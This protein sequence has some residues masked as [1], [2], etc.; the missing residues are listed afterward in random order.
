MSDLASIPSLGSVSLDESDARVLADLVNQWSA[1]RSRNLLRSVYFD[2]KNALRDLGISIPPQLKTMEAVLGWPAKSVT[3]LSARCN[4]D[5]FVIPGGDQDPFDLG[6][7]LVDNNM[8]VE[9][10]QA[11]SSSLI[12]AV[13]FLT[14]T[15]GD[16][17]SGEPEVLLLARSAKDATGIW[18]RRT[19]SL[20]AGL[21]VM[22]TDPSTGMPTQ[23][24]MYQR[25]KVSTF[26]R[27]EGGK[28]IVDVRPNRLGRVWMEPLVFR[29]ELDRPFG[30]SRISRAVMS[31]TDS[32]VRTIVR[33]EV[34]AEF[35]NSPQRYVLGAEE[36]A[37]A[38]DAAKW[39]AITGRLLAISRD[40]EGEVPEVGQFAQQSMVPHMEQLRGWASLF[41]GETGLPVSSL[42]IV[43][44]NPASA[45]AIYAAKEDLVIEA[46]AANRSW[47]ASLRRIATT[48]V[49]LRDGLTEPP[50]EMRQMQAKWRNPATPS[51]V[52]AADALV[53]QATVLPWLAESDVALEALGYDQATITRLRADKRRAESTGRL[54]A[55]IGLASQKKPL[56]PKV[57]EVPSD[58]VEG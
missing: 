18:D 23:F 33:S 34:S 44:D 45:E 50:A 38:G 41:A 42:G 16:A 12:H 54:D 47:G 22:D 17:A 32:A 25:T 30:H 31:L 6:G 21:S 48:A 9:L 8:D 1:K 26:T 40:E 24:V 43:Q 7:L 19:R 57:P 10:P 36:G 2:G 46:A 56:L 20:R 37:F 3:A 4:F 39:K 11:T 5:G 27:N 15:P 28:W 58:G 14:A 29:P 52:S 53:K 35:F 55:L 51:V 13:S 49:M